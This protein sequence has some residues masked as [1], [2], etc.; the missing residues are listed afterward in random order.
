[1]LLGGKATCFF[2]KRSYDMPHNMLPQALTALRVLWPETIVLL[3]TVY[4]R[5]PST[6]VI[7]KCCFF[8]KTG[9]KMDVLNAVRTKGEQ[10]DYYGCLQELSIWVTARRNDVTVDGTLNNFKYTRTSGNDERECWRW[11]PFG[12]STLSFRLLYFV[13]RKANLS[14]LLL[15]EPRWAW[16]VWIT[17][18]LLCGN[19]Q[20]S[21]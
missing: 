2:R 6:S 10:V 12:C 19:K 16:F 20:R 9:V 5:T 3:C 7:I 4:R 14:V 13:F 21:W 15:L 1:M 11:Q 17:F 18:T 8:R